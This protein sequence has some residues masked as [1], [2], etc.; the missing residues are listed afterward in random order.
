LPAGVELVSRTGCRNRVT[1]N[2]STAEVA[3]LEVLRDWSSLVEVDNAEA[4]GIIK[5][6]LDD[7]VLRASTLAKVAVTEPPSVRKALTALLAN[8]G[9]RNEAAKISGAAL[10]VG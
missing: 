5:A 3:L 6:H 2:A 10:T 4:T 7:G 9:Y 1:A 8:C